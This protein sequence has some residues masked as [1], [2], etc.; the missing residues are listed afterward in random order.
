MLRDGA[1]SSNFLTS[2]C[3]FTL[4][5]FA[6]AAANNDVCRLFLLESLCDLEAVDC[7]GYTPLLLAAKSGHIATSKILL[8]A[9]A[10]IFVRV[11]PGLL[12]RSLRYLERIFTSAPR[13]YPETGRN[14]FQVAR[15]NRHEDLL[16][17]LLE[18]LS[19]A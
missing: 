5:H 15:E 19:N 18:H 8:D 11:K 12:T 13:G 10:D 1:P 17:V 16:V 7:E 4:L 14:V 9:G 6:V 3:S 2:L